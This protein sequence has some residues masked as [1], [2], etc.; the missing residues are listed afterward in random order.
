MSDDDILCVVRPSASVEAEPVIRLHRWIV[1]RDGSG[2]CYFV[3]FKDGGLTARLSTPIIE[4]DPATHCG[5]TS[6][7][8]I[9]ELVGAV[10]EHRDAELAWLVLSALFGI[11]NQA[12]APS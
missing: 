5:R 8:R 4:F 6:S 11:T 12:G 9:Y 1:R 3:G 2:N 10:G 7:G